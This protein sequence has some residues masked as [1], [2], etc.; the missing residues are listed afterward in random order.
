MVMRTATS[1]LPGDTAVSSAAKMQ[2][3]RPAM[4]APMANATIFRRLT[5]MPIA[6]AA[7]GSSRNAF[8]ARPTRDSLRR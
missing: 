4:P 6:S 3:T 2:P 1:K 5:G 7:S 8:H